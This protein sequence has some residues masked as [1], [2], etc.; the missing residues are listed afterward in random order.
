[1]LSNFGQREDIERALS[2]GADQFMVK[3]N[4]TLDEIVQEVKK[5]MSSP[6][7]DHTPVP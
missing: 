1:M 5:I 4:F 2:A 3:A 6:R 7:V